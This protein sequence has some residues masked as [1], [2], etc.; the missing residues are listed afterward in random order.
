MAGYRLNSDG[1]CTEEDVQFLMV[2][3]G[4]QI[5]DVPLTPDEKSNGYLTAVVG[6]ENGLQVDFDRKTGTVYWVEGKEDEEENVCILCSQFP[7]WKST[8]YSH[9]SFETHLQP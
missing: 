5:V 1:R 9:N 4:S 7:N 8:C 6:V 2:M 3:R